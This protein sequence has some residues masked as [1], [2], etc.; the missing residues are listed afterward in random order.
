M[1]NKGRSKLVNM[2]QICLG[3]KKSIVEWKKS[4]WG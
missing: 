2:Q 4:I 3:L 1:A